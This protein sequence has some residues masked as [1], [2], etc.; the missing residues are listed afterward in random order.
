MKQ[1]Q[2]QDP[3]REVSGTGQIHSFSWW[4]LK[5]Q[6]AGNSAVTGYRGHKGGGGGVKGQAEWLSILVD[7]S[8]THPP[9]KLAIPTVS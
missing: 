3:P 7:Y 9:A 1:S 4:Y 5:V 6:G 2:L 8:F